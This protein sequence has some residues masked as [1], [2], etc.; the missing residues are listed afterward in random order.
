MADTEYVNPLDVAAA[1]E[2]AQLGI[3]TTADLA[4]G[5]QQQ[6]SAVTGEDVIPPTTPEVPPPPPPEPAPPPSPE[7]PP[8]VPE[9]P[10]PPPVTAAPP[11]TDSDA[12][13]AQRETPEWK[14]WQRAREEKRAAREAREELQR[15]R[16]RA[17]QLEAE[18]AALRA[19]LEQRERLERGESVEPQEVDPQVQMQQRLEMLEEQLRERRVTDAIVQ[20]E[21][22]FRSERP[23]YDKALEYLVTF[24]R[25]QAEETGQLDVVADRVR[26]TVPDQVRQ[27]AM[28][29]SLTEAEAARD[30]AA[31]YIFLARR[32]ELVEGSARTGKPL[33][34]AVYAM[35]KMRGYQ[36]LTTQNGQPAITQPAPPPPQNLSAAEQQRAR[37]FDTAANTLSTMTT[38]A[39]PVA[40][41]ITSRSQLGA[42]PPAEQ[43]RIIIQYDTE[44]AQGK[45]PANWHE[46]LTD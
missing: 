31:G 3:S 21:N 35:A 40:R 30:L 22:R 38:S 16:E 2:E 25:R 11:P 4:P 34:E 18:R 5:L 7:V 39:A 13:P 26:T 32:Q 15:E 28:Q 42:L 23:D 44:A 8:A 1:A 41:E 14:S 27:L 33:P 20:Q 9:P 12:E 37:Q 29:K 43:E 17:Q 36:G 46:H 19:Q 6:H 45:R 24:E 10:P